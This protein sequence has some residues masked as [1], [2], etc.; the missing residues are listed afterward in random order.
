MRRHDVALARE[1]LN[2][3]YP[4]AVLVHGPVEKVMGID[5]SVK[6]LSWPSLRPTRFADTLFFDRL[7]RRLK[8]CCLI[9]NFGARAIMMTIGGL[10]R[11]PVRIHWHHT[12][13]SQIET[14]VPYSPLR[15]RLLRLRARIP[16]GLMTHAIAN[17]DAA[18]QDLTDSF[19]V[20]AQKC[21][22][23]WNSLEDPWSKAELAPPANAGFPGS[24]HFVCVGRF[25]PSKGQDVLVKAMARVVLR[26]PNATIEFI[27]EGTT[28]VSCE[29]A[30]RGLGLEGCCRFTGAL[31]HEDVLR[32]MARAW[33]VVV[34]SRQE[35]FGLVNIES[36]AVGVPVIGSD[37]GGIA[38]IVRAGVDGFLFPAGDYD[39]LAQ[40][41][42][43]LIEDEPLRAQMGANARSRF[44]ECFESTRAVRTQANWIIQQVRNATNGYSRLRADLPIAERP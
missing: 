30:A 25:A 7:L 23:F 10:R 18:R 39:A 13:S 9:S 14:D 35:A 29:A 12:L 41:M 44:L 37:T 3:G 4:A 15:L 31:P 27:G 6:I 24:R 17:S 38:E 1:L 5:P 16:F 21:R 11:V 36:M 32:R 42:I 22:V 8:P 43:D 20:P 34:P 28:K 26:R 40:R 19:G 2:L 33:A